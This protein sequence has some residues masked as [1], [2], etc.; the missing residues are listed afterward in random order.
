MVRREAALTAG[1]IL[2]G[3]LLAAKAIR[4]R[5]AI[6][7]EGRVVMIPGGSRGLGLVVARELG[8]LGA[9]VVLVARD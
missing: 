4:S 7:F 5:R 2:A 3:T 1:G 8:R 6:R 9:R